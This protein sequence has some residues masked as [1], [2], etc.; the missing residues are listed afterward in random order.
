MDTWCTLDEASEL[1]NTPI[2]Q[3]SLN[4]ANSIIEVWAGVTPVDHD[5]IFARRKRDILLLK[6]AEAFQAAWLEGKPAVLQRSDTDQVIQDGLQYSKGDRDM[7]VLAPL[8]KA[9]LVQLS[10]RRD[11]TVSPLTPDQA[12]VLRKKIY[13]DVSREFFDFDEDDWGPG[14]WEAL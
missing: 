14:R 7:H 1:T 9:S 13:P 2:S 8:A 6:K 10:W 3:G 11:R 4:L 5:K 12:A